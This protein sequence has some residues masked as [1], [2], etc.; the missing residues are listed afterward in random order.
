MLDLSA[1]RKIIYFHIFVVSSLSPPLFLLSLVFF[2]MVLAQSVFMYSHVTASPRNSRSECEFQ[3]NRRRINNK[4]E[5][6]HTY[7]QSYVYIYINYTCSVSVAKTLFHKSF[8]VTLF[9][10][11]TCRILFIPKY[12]NDVRN[13][14]IYIY[15]YE[16]EYNSEKIFDFYPPTP[17]REE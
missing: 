6:T 13:L 5:D 1:H 3:K 2:F 15:I 4:R 7:T 11:S 8:R 9:L 14:H 10:S 16:K 12:T 17:L